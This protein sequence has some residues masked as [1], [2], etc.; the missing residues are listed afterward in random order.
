[1]K[2]EKYF[3]SFLLRVVGIAEVL[4]VNGA[5]V[6]AVRI[7]DLLQDG[8]KIYNKNKK[9]ENKVR[10]CVANVF[11]FWSLVISIDLFNASIRK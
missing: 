5:V 3:E 4:K 7:V 1:M 11:N 9:N 2:I 10:F 8:V 6:L